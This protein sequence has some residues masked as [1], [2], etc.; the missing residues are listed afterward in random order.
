MGHH[1]LVSHAVIGFVTLCDLLPVYDC[2]THGH[3]QSV[4]YAA[5]EIIWPLLRIKKIIPP[6]MYHDRFL[7]S[8]AHF[9]R[10]G[11]VAVTR[12]SVELLI[13]FVW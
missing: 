6:A 8:V 13:I 5:D 1:V 3:H 7:Q 4:T 10:N 12:F 9:L 11:A 2:H